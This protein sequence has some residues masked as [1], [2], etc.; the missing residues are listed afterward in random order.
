[1]R[2]ATDGAG[3]WF[4]CRHHRPW[5]KRVAQ[6]SGGAGSGTA[7]R[8]RPTGREK[9]PPEILKR[10]GALLREDTAG[11]PTGRRGVWTGKRLRTISRELAQLAVGTAS[12]PQHGSSALGGTGLRTARQPQESLPQ[13]RS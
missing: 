9:K 1:G 2:R 8:R 3:V 6:S 5:S 11:D 4:G 7:Q 13:Q 10:L 12:L